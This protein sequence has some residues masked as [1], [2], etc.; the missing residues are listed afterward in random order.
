M[1]WRAVCGLCGGHYAGVVS[2]TRAATLPPAVQECLDLGGLFVVNH[3]AGKD[4]QAMLIHLRAAGIPDAQMIIVHADLGEIEWPGN[5]D[6]IGKN[7]GAVPVIVATPARSF[8]D[9]VEARQRFPSPAQRQCTSDLKRGPIER[10]VRRYLKA[11]PQHG[12]RVVNCMGMRAQE[13]P[14]RAKAQ[15]LKHSVRNSKAGRVWLDWLPIHP[16]TTAQV[17]AAIHLAGQ[18]PH[19]VYAQ[20][21]TR[22]S[23]SFCIMASRADLTTAARLRPALYRRYVETERR[24]GFTL[25]PSRMPLEQITGVAA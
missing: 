9:M 18:T 1:E 7:A 5:L 19:P 6:Q 3:S 2:V 10:E 12:G 16:L 4:S 20:G 15:P 17:F 13:S 8:F 21:M 22:L 14:A 23:C 25:S 24:L 11:N